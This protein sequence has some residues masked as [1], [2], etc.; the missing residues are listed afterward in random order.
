MPA[1]DVARAWIGRIVRDR[2]GERIGTVTDVFYDQESDGPGWALV[3]LDDGA[4]RRLVP[5]GQALEEGEELRV[6]YDHAT[7]R[8]APGMDPGGR[9]WPRQEAELYAHYGLDYSGPQEM[10][11]DDLEAQVD[12]LDPDDDDIVGAGRRRG[13]VDGQ[14]PLP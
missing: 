7:V 13:R 9:L 5:V 12:A 2:D 10:D 1:F 3:E 4:A 11:L 14:E 8:G 6:R